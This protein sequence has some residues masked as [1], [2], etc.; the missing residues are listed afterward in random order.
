MVPLYPDM[1]VREYLAF[2]ARLKGVPRARLAGRLED[3]RARCSL[4]SV[5]DRIIGQ[6]SRGHWQ[7]IAWPTAWCTNRGC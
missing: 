2:R 6:L 1:R 7:R 5:F 4:E 3:V